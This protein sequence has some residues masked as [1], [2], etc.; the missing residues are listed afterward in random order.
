MAA[1]HWQL[2]YTKQSQPVTQVMQC[3]TLDTSKHRV[4]Q[5]ERERERARAGGRAGWARDGV[6]LMSYPV[7]NVQCMQG[8]K[9]A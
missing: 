5:R 3:T 6:K 1:T 9:E 7:E 2:V 4:H 8:R